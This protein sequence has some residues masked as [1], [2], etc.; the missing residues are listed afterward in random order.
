M[1]QTLTKVY[2]STC[3]SHLLSEIIGCKDQ[4]WTLQMKCLNSCQLMHQVVDSVYTNA[5]IHIINK[6][7]YVD[8][9]N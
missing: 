9:D 7:V 8:K 5:H 1:L 6:Y 3:K 2:I 4:T